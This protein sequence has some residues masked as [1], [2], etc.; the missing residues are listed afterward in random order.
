MSALF[1]LSSTVEYVFAKE[2]KKK[3][4]TKAKHFKIHIW[5][6]ISKRGATKLVI[7]FRDHECK[8]PRGNL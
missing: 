5:G 3:F 6:G 8:P 7:F 1:N 2:A 4:K